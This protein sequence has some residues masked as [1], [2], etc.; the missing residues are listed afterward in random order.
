MK[1]DKEHDSYEAE[2][3]KLTFSWRDD[4]VTITKEWRASG[5]ISATKLNPSETLALKSFVEGNL[6]EPQTTTIDEWV[7]LV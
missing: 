7:D 1:R 2:N 3:Y 6:E 4:A 5:Y